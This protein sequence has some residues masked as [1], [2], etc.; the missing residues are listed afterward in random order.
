MRSAVDQMHLRIW[1]NAQRIWSNVAHL[2]KC[3]AAHLVKRCAFGQ[4]PCNW[5]DAQH[6]CPNALS[7]WPNAQIG[8]MR[9]TVLVKR[10]EMQYACTPS[11]CRLA[12]T[13]PSVPYYIT[14]SG[15]AF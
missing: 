3:R 1:T 9:L 15:L 11:I 6:I 14:R 13:L 10:S 4:M 5:S 2:V 12:S 7:I 8:Q